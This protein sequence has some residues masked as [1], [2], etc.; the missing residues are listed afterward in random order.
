M[1]A[2]P[3]NQIKKAT[4]QTVAFFACEKYASGEGRLP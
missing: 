3:R 2:S 4:A 1:V